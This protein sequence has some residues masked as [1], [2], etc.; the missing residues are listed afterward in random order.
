VNRIWQH[1]FG[2]GIVT[3]VD[4]FG[5]TG[6]LPSHPELLDYLSNRFIDEG[7]SVKKMVR[8]LV[9]SRSYRLGSDAPATHLESDPG[10]RLVWRHSPRRM[11][12]EEI[13][14]SILAASGELQLTRPSDAPVKELKMVE[15]R[16]NGREAATIHE[17][18]N[19]G[20]HRSVYLPLLRGVIPKSL[21]AFDPVTQTLVTG[22]RDATTVPTQALF[23]L[24]SAFVR[25][26]SLA[27]A[28][29]L[30][31]DPQT[32]ATSLISRI[33][34]K[35]LGREPQQ[36]EIDRALAFI[37]DYEASYEIP[38]LASVD[39]SDSRGVQNSTTDAPVNPDDIPR[40]DQTTGEKVVAAKDGK[41]AAWMALSQA[42]FASAEFRFIR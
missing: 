27:L 31:G 29:Q 5:V 38:V 8:T 15:M 9:L 34:L 17:K 32:S 14:D 7:W 4:N 35:A 40:D 11:A 28:K 1:L 20:L 36:T 22:Q 26:Q 10:N 23:M 37:R 42:L 41:T 3:T 30:A 25:E 21:E 24:N 13:R 19:N 33:Y 12:A 18:A 6:D 39:T 16:D 2:Q